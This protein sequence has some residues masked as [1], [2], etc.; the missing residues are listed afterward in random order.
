MQ[1]L[2]ILFL[3][4]QPI[5]VEATAYCGCEVCCGKRTMVTASGYRISPGDRFLACEKSIPFG[6][7]FI[8]PGY[9]SGKP[10]QNL[11]RG[12][13]ITKGHVDLYFDSHSDA[14]NYGRHHIII[15]RLK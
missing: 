2:L 11:D 14:I 10:T 3:L 8:V 6:T 13:A 1:I 5:N 7:I 4:Y 9:N 15:W 12:G